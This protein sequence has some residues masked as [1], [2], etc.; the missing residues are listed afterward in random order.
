MVD[1]GNWIEAAQRLADEGK[2]QEAMELCERNL[3]DQTPSAQAFYLMGLLHDAAGRFEQ[4]SEHYRK[5]LYWDPVHQ[6]ALVH[7]GAALLREGD[8]SAAQRLFDRAK[9]AERGGSE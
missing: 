1:T 5:A 9:R 3:D 2:L 7:L 8:A 4:A 6:E